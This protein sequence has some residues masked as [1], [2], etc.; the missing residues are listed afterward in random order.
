[1]TVSTPHELDIML[2]TIPPLPMLEAFEKHAS[3]TYDLSQAALTGRDI[4][5][6]IVRG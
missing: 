3:E 2:E 5:K 6:R 4:G 1:M